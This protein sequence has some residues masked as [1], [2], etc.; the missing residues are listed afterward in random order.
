MKICLLFTHG[1]TMAPGFFES[2]YSNLCVSIVLSLPLLLLQWFC[3]LCPVLSFSLI[4]QQCCRLFSFVFSYPCLLWV[5]CP[6][7]HLLYV[8]LV[9][10][11]MGSLFPSM[12]VCTC[13]PSVT[14]KLPL[15][16]TLRPVQR[17]GIPPRELSFCSHKSKTVR[18][19]PFFFGMQSIGTA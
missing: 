13:L 14:Q 19:L 1:Y 18:S 6:L 2:V 11:P 10:F 7:F 4:L 3:L 12:G 8:S 9:L 16:A 5:L 17:V 15:S